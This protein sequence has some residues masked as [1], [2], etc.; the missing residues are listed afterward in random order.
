[1]SFLI[2]SKIAESVGY[3]IASLRKIG[4]IISE[5]TSQDDILEKL[6]QTKA[7]LHEVSDD[8]IL[9]KQTMSEYKSLT[10]MGFL[11]R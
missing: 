9:S 8:T 2:H 4:V 7:M 6:S 5:S 1:M 3:G 11:A 10:A